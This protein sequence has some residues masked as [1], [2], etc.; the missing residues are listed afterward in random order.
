MAKKRGSK[1][2]GRLYLNLIEGIETFP[3]E[4][5]NPNVLIIHGF[6]NE[7][8]KAGPLG[9]MLMLRPNEFE[10]RQRDWIHPET[11][12]RFHVK[13]IWRQGLWNYLAVATFLGLPHARVA[14]K[15]FHPDYYLRHPMT[16]KRIAERFIYIMQKLRSQPTALFMEWFDRAY[17]PGR[18]TLWRGYYAHALRMH[19]PHKRV[20][21][22]FGLKI[23]EPNL[24]EI[25][26][27]MPEE[28][29]Y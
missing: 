14:E 13:T 6:H 18:H 1:S 2:L 28:N 24:G 4:L 23:A 8:L 19:A 20:N 22:A 3:E 16:P 21:R 29:F 5:F 9:I 12:R 10:V 7:I 17:R 27:A 25:C 26:P 15:I 11:K